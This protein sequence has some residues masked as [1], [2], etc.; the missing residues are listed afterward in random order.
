[1]LFQRAIGV[2]YCPLYGIQPYSTSKIFRYSQKSWHS[3]DA[4][5]SSSYGTRRCKSQT[6]VDEV[7]ANRWKDPLPRSSNP[8]ETA[9]AISGD[10]SSLAWLR[11]SHGQEITEI[12]PVFCSLLCRLFADISRVSSPLNETL[13]K[14]QHSL[15]PFFVLTNNDVV[16]N[17]EELLKFLPMRTARKLH[18]SAR[19]IPTSAVHKRNAFYCSHRKMA[20]SSHLN[21]G[22]A[23]SPVQSIRWQLPAADSLL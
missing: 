2:L 21:T 5:T 15:F 12:F 1:M 8:S 16:R 22:Q 19:S 20:Q 13:Q 4:L 3:L 11:R 17:L 6:R 14:E 9:G 18:A 23:C 10:N 7:L